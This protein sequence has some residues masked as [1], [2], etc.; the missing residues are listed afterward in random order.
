[1]FFL[2]L[3]LSFTHARRGCGCGWGR[4]EAIGRT[5]EC[6]VFIVPLRV[7]YSPFRSFTLS[8]VPRDE[9]DDQCLTKE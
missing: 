7:C 6:R 3:F 9:E 8:A 1:M 4:R 5:G 2:S